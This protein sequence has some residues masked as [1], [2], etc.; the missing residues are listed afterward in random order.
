MF[1]TSTARRVARLV[2]VTRTFTAAC[3][4]SS[5]RRRIGGGEPGSADAGTLSSPTTGRPTDAGAAVTP[6]SLP[7]VRDVEGACAAPAACAG[8]GLWF[9]CATPH[10]ASAAATASAVAGAAATGL[11]A[12]NRATR[13]YR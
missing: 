2:I 6:Y 13:L 7:P 4:G 11:S 10:W 5:M 8:A 12:R 3:P 9:A 1:R